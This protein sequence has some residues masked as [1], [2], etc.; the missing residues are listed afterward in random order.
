MKYGSVPLILFEGHHQFVP[1]HLKAQE[2]QRFLLQGSS[3]HAGNFLAE[4]TQQDKCLDLLRNN[5][6]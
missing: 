4:G 3:L 5:L 2:D 6:T 1:T